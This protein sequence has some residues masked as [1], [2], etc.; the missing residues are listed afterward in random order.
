LETLSRN[1]I[2]VRLAG[3]LYATGR[4]AL[5]MP[6]S[7]DILKARLGVQPLSRFLVAG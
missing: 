7:V 1:E 3:A 2:N 5:G 6:C 4:S